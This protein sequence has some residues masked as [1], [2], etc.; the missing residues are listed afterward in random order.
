M[1]DRLRHVWLPRICF[2]VVLAVALTLVGAVVIAPWLRLENP[3]PLFALFAQSGPVRRAA[4]ASA[5]GLVV[6]ACVFFRASGPRPSKPS[7]KEPPPGNM[8]GA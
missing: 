7:H 8:A 2:A 3:P 6:T 5:L 1:W 4:L